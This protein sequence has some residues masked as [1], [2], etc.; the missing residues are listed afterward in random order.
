MKLA[1]VVTTSYGED[2]IS[3]EEWF[4]RVPETPEEREELCNFTKIKY[5]NKVWTRNEKGEWENE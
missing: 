2:G 3:H 5:G 1:R 4:M